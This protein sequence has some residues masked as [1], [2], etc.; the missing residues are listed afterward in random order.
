MGEELARQDEAL[1]PVRHVL[2]ST[3]NFITN[4]LELTKRPTD[5]SPAGIASP[6]ME[7]FATEWIGQPA[8]FTY[9]AGTMP[10]VV[11]NQHLGALA[12]LMHPPLKPLV[13]KGLIRVVLDN[14]ARAWWLWDPG[15]DPR[16]R[17]RRALNERI[18]SLREAAK[19]ARELGVDDGAEAGVEEVYR[20]AR[21]NG[22]EAKQFVGSGRPT[23]TDLIRKMNAGSRQP[24]AMAYYRSGSAIIHGVAWGFMQVSE[25]RPVGRGGVY[26]VDARPRGVQDVALDS[27]LAV[28]VL[29]DAMARRN[30]TLG[31]DPRIWDNWVEGAKRNLG[32]HLSRPRT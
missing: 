13:D 4:F 11:A 18:Y 24:A 31:A 16:E 9:S 14:A 6:T 21:A 28:Q 30:T 15:I 3:S 1:R 25:V 19:L 22:Y 10:L 32:K 23:A 29:F 2:Q 27:A 7:G 17:H 20:H 5:D 12:D 26:R 8:V